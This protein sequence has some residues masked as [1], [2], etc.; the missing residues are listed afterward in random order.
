MADGCLGLGTEYTEPVAFSG[1]LVSQSVG[2]LSRCLAAERFYRVLLFSTGVASFVT[3]KMPHDC[4]PEPAA[5]QAR[6]NERQND[7]SALS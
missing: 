5:T 6:A 4:A 3:T 7:S 1:L 2:R